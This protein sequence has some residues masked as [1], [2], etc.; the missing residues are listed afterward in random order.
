MGG[1]SEIFLLFYR[2][3]GNR[4]C[5][6]LPRTNLKFKDANVSV[7]QETFPSLQAEFPGAMKA[8]QLMRRD[9]MPA[10]VRM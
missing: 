3:R 4:K 7:G 10:F 8:D 5:V 9:R 1:Q 6:D 2:E